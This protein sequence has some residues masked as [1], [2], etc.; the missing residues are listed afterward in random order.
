MS[1]RK[2]NG[3]VPVQYLPADLGFLWLVFW[4][5]SRSLVLI[6]VIPKVVLSFTTHTRKTISSCGGRFVE[7]GSRSWSASKG[8]GSAGWWKDSPSNEQMSS[9]TQTLNVTKVVRIILKD[10]VNPH[11]LCFCPL[12]SFKSPL[13]AT[14]P[15][16]SQQVYTRACQR[17]E[18]VEE[19][20]KS[21]FAWRYRDIW[22]ILVCTKPLEHGIY[23][24]PTWSVF[25]VQYPCRSNLAFQVE[26]SLLAMDLTLKRSHVSIHGCRG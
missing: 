7:S 24:S 16:I 10:W 21:H 17:V 2:W 15:P 14:W 13:P 5:C 11:S 18:D 8:R 1:A 3:L 25:Q 6:D 20:E 19:P 9:Q 23:P 22:L 26:S 12:D 4:L